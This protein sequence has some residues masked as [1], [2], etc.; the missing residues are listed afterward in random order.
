[1]V[2]GETLWIT[3]TTGIVGYLLINT[4]RICYFSDSNKQ[5]H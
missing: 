4:R 5:Y 1:M 3:L 2:G